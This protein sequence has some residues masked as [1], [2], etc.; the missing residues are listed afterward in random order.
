DADLTA[1]IGGQPSLGRYA[2][3]GTLFATV[4]PSGPHRI[5]RHPVMKRHPITPMNDADLRNHLADPGWD[6][7]VL[8][9]YRTCLAGDE[10]MRNALN[11]QLRSGYRRIFF[12][13]SSTADIA[14]I[15]RLLWCMSHD[16]RLLCIGASSVAECLTPFIR[17]QHS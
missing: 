3:F 7:M 16:K 4:G 12:D 17:S 6:R 10:Q 1:I 5:D 14:R 8:M 9:D 2:L 13:V 11:E 15:G